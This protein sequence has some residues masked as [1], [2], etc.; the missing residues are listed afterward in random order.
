MNNY[1]KARRVVITG[2]GAVTPIGIGIEAFWNSLKE[3]KSGVGPITCFDASTFSSKVAGEVKDFDATDYMDPL[4]AKKMDRFAHFAVI[5]YTT[6]N[7]APCYDSS[8]V[9]SIPYI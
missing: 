4:S 3:G 1:Y 7:S 5:S 2:L 6:Y 9:H 8:P